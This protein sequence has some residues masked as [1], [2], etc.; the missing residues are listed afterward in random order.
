MLE[1]GHSF[2]V[3]PVVETTTGVDVYIGLLLYLC[4]LTLRG[5]ES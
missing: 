2:N 4:T 1:N 3:D 5:F